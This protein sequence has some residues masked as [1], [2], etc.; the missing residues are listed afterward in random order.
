MVLQVSGSNYVLADRATQERRV[1]AWGALLAQCGQEGSRIASLQWLERTVP[2]S[3]Q[4]LQ[5]WWAGRGDHESPYADAYRDLID[6]AGPAAT[7]H[8]AYV[9]VSIDAHRMRRAPSGRSAA[10]RKAPPRCC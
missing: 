3:G 5:E 1:A 10:A 6:D 9:A 7:R 8:E 2:D 4:A